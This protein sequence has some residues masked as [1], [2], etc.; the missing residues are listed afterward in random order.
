MKK[1]MQIMRPFQSDFPMY[2]VV[3]TICQ[4][5]GR[6]CVDR[7]MSTKLT[8]DSMKGAKGSG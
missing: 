2:L 6:G 5:G 4:K 8:C 1:D 7:P 3:A